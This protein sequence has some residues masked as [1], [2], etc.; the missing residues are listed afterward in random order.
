MAAQGGFDAW[1]ASR[2]SVH[3]DPAWKAALWQAFE[4]AQ[5]PA[6]RSYR[7]GDRITVGEGFRWEV[8]IEHDASHHPSTGSGLRVPVEEAARQLVSATSHYMHAF[9]RG[10]EVTESCK[11]AFS[12]VIGPRALDDD[13]ADPGS[14]MGYI[15]GSDDDAMSLFGDDAVADW[16]WQRAVV[17]YTARPGDFA[18]TSIAI[19]LSPVDFV[20]SRTGVRCEI[21]EPDIVS[22]DVLKS[23]FFHLL[24]TMDTLFTRDEHDGYNRVPPL[25]VDHAIEFVSE[26][27]RMIE[28]SP[29]GI[30]RPRIESACVL[31]IVPYYGEGQAWWFKLR[32]LDASLLAMTFDV[33]LKVN[34]REA[35][36]LKFIY[37]AALRVA[38]H[39]I[40][41]EL[42]LRKGNVGG[43]TK[44]AI[45]DIINEFTSPAT[46]DAK[47]RRIPLLIRYHLRTFW[48]TAS[49]HRVVVT[50]VHPGTGSAEYS[51]YMHLS[52]HDGVA[53][54][55][56]TLIGFI[57]EG[58]TTPGL[59]SATEQKLAGAM[60][61]AIRERRFQRGTENS[62]RVDRILH[63]TPGARM[64]A[65]IRSM[66]RAYAGLSTDPETVYEVFPVDRPRDKLRR[67]SPRSRGEG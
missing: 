55:N 3:D 52:R 42:Y 38:I 1:Q 43:P 21:H 37:C 26:L 65:E 18:A 24:G 59:L 41:N 5:A 7:S 15:D 32:P 9:T 47:G 29:T 62:F 20:V 12:V 11:V 2:Q 23:A 19:N 51:L 66:I 63:D 8:R 16:A 22:D 57:E 28:E 54:T 50:N 67:L 14:Y 36:L 45:Q 44:S 17:V 30:V 4:E 31:S 34:A 39:V 10:F 6:T 48:D 40:D 46:R 33:N 56:D 53:C 60:L 13:S 25:S 61:E 35:A 58:A 27:R 64:P 49:G